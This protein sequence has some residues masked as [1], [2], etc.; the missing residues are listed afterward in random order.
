MKQRSLFLAEVG[1]QVRGGGRTASLTVHGV[2][3]PVNT[4]HIVDVHAEGV[5]MM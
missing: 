1:A 5:H 2:L 4:S 3:R